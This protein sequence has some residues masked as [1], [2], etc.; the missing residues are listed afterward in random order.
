[1]LLL[2]I[3]R[4]PQFEAVAECLPFSV[5]VQYATVTLIFLS[6]VWASGSLWA[7]SVG[8]SEDSKWTESYRP[9]H[10]CVIAY[11]HYKT[12]I[13]LDWW[14]WYQKDCETENRLSLSS[15]PQRYQKYLDDVVPYRLPRWA[16]VAV[17]LVIYAVR[18][19][20]LQGWYIVTYALAIYL[21]NIFIAFI[22][23]KFEPL[24]EEEDISKYCVC[25]TSFPSLPPWP[26]YESQNG[27]G[28]EF[29]Q[30]TN[31]GCTCMWKYNLVA[32]HS[33]LEGL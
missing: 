17:L 28:N 18:V 22:S 4:P 21:L 1:M 5:W 32:K 27:L 33:V 2:S 6:I 13:L 19:M 26:T 15:L 9:N 16:F 11:I 23:P 8:A 24:L 14:K 7:F 31:W 20:L 3:I 12:E 29:C 10:W 25:L 30:L